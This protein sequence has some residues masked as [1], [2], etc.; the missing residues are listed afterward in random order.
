M[1]TIL[2]RALSEWLP[3]T[4]PDEGRREAHLRRLDEIASQEFAAVEK[5]GLTGHPQLWT[6]EQHVLR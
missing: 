6:I 4:P 5:Q 2:Q 1:H 3:D